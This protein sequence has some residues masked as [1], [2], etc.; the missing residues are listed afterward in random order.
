MNAT[1]LDQIIEEAQNECRERLV[2]LSPHIIEAASAVLEESQESETAKAKVKVALSL[3]IDLTTHPVTW[4]VDGAVGIRRVAK[5]DANQADDTPELASG[6]G[7]G[8]K[9]KGEVE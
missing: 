7:K 8:R 9:G 5:G 4:V 6:F 2:E 3:T 1:Q